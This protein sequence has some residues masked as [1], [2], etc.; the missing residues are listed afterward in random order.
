MKLRA[1]L[2]ELRKAE[3]TRQADVTRIL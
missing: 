1:W 3:G 2:L